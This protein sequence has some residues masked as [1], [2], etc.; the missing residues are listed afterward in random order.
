MTNSQVI[1]LIFTPTEI[2]PIHSNSNPHGH[3]HTNKWRYMKINH[4]CTFFIFAMSF[5]F[6][7]PGPSLLNRH[8]ARILA[9]AFSHSKESEAIHLAAVRGPQGDRKGPQG[10]DRSYGS[11][12]DLMVLKKYGGDMTYFW[13]FLG[14][15]YDIFIWNMTYMTDLYTILRIKN[16]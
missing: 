10:G 11:C 3:T 13:D 14:I 1:C 15:L 12:E 9:E 16:G 8:T 2:A 7:F 6:I 5:W 4:F